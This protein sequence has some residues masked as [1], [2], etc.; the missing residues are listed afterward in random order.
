MVSLL[1][2]GAV[3]MPELAAQPPLPDTALPRLPAYGVG[4]D[5]FWIGGAVAT[6]PPADRPYSEL[7][8]FLRTL[9]VTIAERRIWTDDLPLIDTLAAA[10]APDQRLIVSVPPIMHGGYGREVELYPFDSAQSYYYRNTFVQQSGGESAYNQV[11]ED[12]AGHAPQE[13]V[14]DGATTAPNQTV[15]SGIAFGYDA[16]WQTHRTPQYANDPHVQDNV[17]FLYPQVEAYP[18]DPLYIVVRGHLFDAQHGGE[19]ASNGDTLLRIDVWCEVPAG[20]TYGDFSGVPRTA[21]ADTSYRY[22][23]LGV[24]K[25]QLRQVGVTPWD[26]YRDVV[27]RVNA[28]RE[29]GCPL[30]GPLHADNSAH[31]FDVRVRWTGLEKVALRA[32]TLRDSNA[33]LMR[34]SGFSQILFRNQV[35]NQAKRLVFGPAPA[36]PPVPQPSVIRF[37]AGDEGAFYEH[38]AYNVLDSLL[39][40]TFPY[41]DSVTRG[42]RLYR[43]MSRH[44]NVVQ[45]T[46]DNQPEI[47]VELYEGDVLHRTG[48]DSGWGAHP[49]VNVQQWYALADTQL[50]SLAHHNGGRWHIPLMLPTR[51]EVERFN[52]VFQRLHVGS[53]ITG[54]NNPEFYGRWANDLGHAAWSSRRTGKRVLIWPG[55]MA[56]MNVDPRWDANGRFT[57]REI[58]ISHIQEAAEIRAMTTLGLCDGIRGVHYSWIGSDTG[59]YA[60]VSRPNPALDTTR[61]YRFII[62]FGVVGPIT[63]WQE[64]HRDTF[65]LASHLKDSTFIQPR[66]HDTLVDFYTGWGNRLGELRWL[67]GWLPQVGAAM[68]RLR[69]RDAYSVH[70]A[71]EQ[72]WMVDN[73]S[74]VP[75]ARSRPLPATEMVRSVEAY[76]R[77]GRKDSAADTFVELGLFDTLKGAQPI[78]DTMHIFLMNRRV[79]ERPADTPATSALG[80]LLDTLAESRTLRVRLRLQHPDTAQYNFVHVQELAPDTNRLPLANA[81]RAGLDTIIRA[82]SVFA[83]SLRPG[84]GALL[85]ITYCKPNAVVFV[86]DTRFN[87]QRKLVYDGTYWHAV[88][89][90]RTRFWV[91]PLKTD[92]A[93]SDQVYYRR[94]LPVTNATGAIL[95]DPRPQFE[96]MLSDTGNARYC[97]DNRFPSL[98]VRAD[99]TKLADRVAAVVW[100]TYPY[101]AFGFAKPVLTRNVRFVAGDPD[102]FPQAS[103][104]DSIGL[105]FGVDDAQ[106]GTPVVSRLHGGEMFAWSDSTRGIVSAFRKLAG[107]ATWWQ[108]PKTYV[109]CDTV[110]APLLW[111][112]AGQYPTMPPFAHIAGRDSSIGLAWQQPTP[113]GSHIFYARLI[114]TASAGTHFHRVINRMMVSQ[115]EAANHVHPSLDMTQDVWCGAQEG[116]AWESFGGYFDLTKGEGYRETWVHYSSLW[117]ETSRSCNPDPADTTRWR[118]YWDC[119]ENPW[120]WTYEVTRAATVP[121]SVD[122]PV[123]PSVSSINARMRP[124]DSAQPITFSVLMSPVPLYKPMQQS[125]VEYATSF[126][127]PA[128]RAYAI[129]GFAASGAASPTR[130][131]GKHAALFTMGAGRGVEGPVETSREF[132]ARQRPHGYTA[133][134][135]RVFFR[136]SDSAVTAISGT[137][138]DVWASGPAGATPLYLAARPAPQRRTDSRAAVRD[139]FRTEYFRAH[140]STTIG[141]ELAG[142][143]AGDSA[144][145]GGGG[146]SFV[147]ELMDSVTNTAVA[148]LDSFV[149]SAAADSYHVYVARD[150]DL[151]SGTYYVRLRMEPLG[152]AVQSVPYA[153]VYPV[154]ELSTPETEDV[155]AKLRLAER[156][157]AGLRLAAYPN[158]ARSETQ[159]R[160]SVPEAGPFGITVYDN[161]GRAVAWPV[162]NAVAAEG[163]Y[164]LELNI[165]ALPAGAYVVELRT[166]SGRVTARL[167]VIR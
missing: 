113:Y 141:C 122:Q 105:S 97:Y 110:T 89:T 42:V 144:L 35:L 84:G 9:G 108:L 34:G 162:R 118:P 73:V 69:W 158:P 43:A 166:R 21:A 5:E 86:G 62:D 45:H 154:E 14:Y 124:A 31:R 48:W 66:Q 18:Y 149:V 116:L 37:Y 139:L 78:D 150:L 102:A 83:L 39:A 160:F 16:A 146:V 152:L 61:R 20:T 49:G 90:R 99:S 157:G 100:T 4:L 75:Q 71:T 58:T 88:Y 104:I 85:R 117:T 56:P 82:D 2:L 95:W 156:G 165:R 155:A 76:D 80:R 93:W 55:V 1:L 8:D 67:G 6:R 74:G 12:E 64:N 33:H 136:V 30:A 87:N 163:R 24:T 111:M 114:D 98:T 120:Q 28:R 132:F 140:D 54:S 167:A 40:A 91:P 115:S 38:G 47:P 164:L 10:A 135:R 161:A 23:S 112:G 127:W 22:V 128:P 151:L 81:P 52:N 92:T 142:R 143:F 72:A 119:I 121:G 159:L 125:I 153:S 138:H 130:Q 126:I 36:T 103:L 60:E 94:S 109:T 7:W 15:A 57:H 147:A 51:A 19:V 41:G 32:V 25:G 53:Y 26:Q 27:L 107:N 131:L 77:L 137:L 13:R 133:Q 96:V 101:A 129:G 63:T 59:G 46:A 44:H 134:G 70:Y 106:W 3:A 11:M 50:P 145:A 148:G 29:P 65:F 68:A 123:Y 17:S 79:F